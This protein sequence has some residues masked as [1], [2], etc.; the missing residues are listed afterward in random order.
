MFAKPSDDKSNNHAKF[1]HIGHLPAL[2]RP[3]PKLKTTFRGFK[4]ETEKMLSKYM[5]KG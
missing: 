5:E 3:M 1:S 4:G 2:L